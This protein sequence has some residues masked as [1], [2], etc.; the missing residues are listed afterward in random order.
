M[1]RY[2]HADLLFQTSSYLKPPPYGCA[3][4]P[5]KKA[6]RT[7]LYETG[8]ADFHDAE[9]IRETAVSKDGTKSTD[10]YYPEEG[11]KLNGRIRWS[12]M[13]RGYGV[14]RCRRF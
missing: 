1:V 10:Q 5:R 2:N 6:D 3:S 7:A 4:I 14:T 11:D 12:S 8:A 9:V 13:A